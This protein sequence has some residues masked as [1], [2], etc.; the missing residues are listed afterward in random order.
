MDYKKVMLKVVS[1][2]EFRDQIWVHFCYV[3]KDMYDTF[4]YKK[5]EFLL[6]EF[7][8]KWAKEDFAFSKSLS[9]HSNIELLRKAIRDN[10][11]ISD[12]GT[13]GV[14]KY[15]LCKHIMEEIINA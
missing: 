6:T 3:P 8:Q 12:I 10:V 11:Y 2:N 9:R 1:D 13:T 15:W 4:V 5:G 14:T 7:I